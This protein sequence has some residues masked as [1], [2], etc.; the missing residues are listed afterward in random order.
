[1]SGRLTLVFRLVQPV[2][3]HVTLGDSLRVEALFDSH[4][5]LVLVNTSFSLRSGHGRRH[6]SN[7]LVQY[8]VAERVLE[9]LF[10]DHYSEHNPAQGSLS[11]GDYE[12]FSKESAQFMLKIESVVEILRESGLRI[13]LATI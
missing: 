8:D 1:M 2:D 9:A 3:N 10:E 4:A 7:A 6:S 12:R 5:E 13:R 11:D